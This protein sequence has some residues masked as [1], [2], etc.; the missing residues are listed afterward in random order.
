MEQIEHVAV[1]GAG[2]MGSG[3]AALMA[4]SGLTV[5][6]LDLDPAIAQGAVARQ[7]KSGGIVDAAAA[8]RICTG[9]SSKDLACLADADWIVEAAS[10]NLE[11]KSRIFA[12]VD[13]VRKSGSI[14]SSNTS[15]F[16]LSQLLEGVNPGCAG[17]YLITHFFNPPQT[18]RLL[19]LVDGPQTRRQAVEAI[20]ELAQS[21]LGRCVVDCKDTPGFIANRIGNFWMAVAL[22]EAVAANVAVEDADAIL[23]GPFG[24]P[25]GIFALLDLVGID[26]LPV[27][28]QSLRSS[29]PDNDPFQVYPARPALV[30]SMIARGLIGRKA[31]E[32]FYRRDPDGRWSVIDLAS[33]E[34]RDRRPAKVPEINQDGLAGL[35]DDPSSVAHYARRVMIRTLAYAA[36]RLGEI[37]DST[38]SIDT[39]MREGYGWKKGPFALIA[40]LDARWLHDALDASGIAVPHYLRTGI[41][42]AR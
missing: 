29:L 8:A 30:D 33:G 16:C 7:L 5:T 17:D 36:A 22:D 32:G 37:A 12:A 25:M 34:Y 2:V 19:E 18:M 42:G 38:E 11:I 9:S 23:G 14:V 4:N 10:E 13:A 28:W 27:G 39:A 24:T 41:E 6:L 31:G 26:L 21:R 40:S 1:I 15:T 35:M 20:V 3:I